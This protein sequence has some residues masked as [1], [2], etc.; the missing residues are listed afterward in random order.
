M[1]LYEYECRTCGERHDKLYEMGN[2]DRIVS[3]PFCGKTA[4]RVFTIGCVKTDTNNPLRGFGRMLGANMKTRKQAEAVMTARGLGMV[5]Q[6]ECD[7][8]ER[9]AR[10]EERRLDKVVADGVREYNNLPADV[11][12]ADAAVIRKQEQ[13]KPKVKAD[14]M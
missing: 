8:A 5:S 4:H 12:K 11:L 1:I 2:A 14:P 9:D 13:A 10:T 3:C 6:R 7:D